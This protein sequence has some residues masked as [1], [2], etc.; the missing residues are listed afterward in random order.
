MA[1]KPSK[2]V[3]VI[4]KANSSDPIKLEY[5][6]LKKAVMTLRAINHPL[7]KEIIELVE[8]KK[9]VTVTEIYIKMRLEQSVA[10]QHLAILRR[11]EVLKTKRDGKFI[12]YSVNAKRIDE[13]AALVEKLAQ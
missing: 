4:T 9:Q 1:A 5:S 11:A 8:E 7:R 12:Y 10:S 3:L 2:E 6:T 13:I